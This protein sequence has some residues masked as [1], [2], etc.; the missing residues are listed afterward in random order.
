MKLTQK[1]CEN[2]KPKEKS[3]KLSDGE[4][5]YLEIMQN[6]SKYFRMKYRFQGKEKRLAL[7]VYP[8]VSLQ[9][10]REKRRSAKK[11]LEQG[12]D[13]SE[14][15]KLEKINHQ[16]NYEN[17][18]KTIAYE[19]H[20]QNAHT[21]TAIHGARIL[22]R[23]EKD[24][25]PQMGD[26]PIQEI[27]PPEVLAAIRQI[28]AR[29]VNELA[30]R[31]MQ[32]CSQVFRY[33][34]A[35]G[36]TGRDVT[37]DLRGALKPVVTKHLA[38]LKEAELPDFLYRLNHYEECGGSIL[39]KLAFQFLILTFVRSSEIR[40][41]TW[42]EIDY[43][44]AQWR[45]PASRMKMKEQHIVPLSKQSIHLLKQIHEITGNNFNNYILPNQYNPRKIM[46]ENTFLRVI[47]VLGY[48]GRTTAHGFRSVASTILN[49]R[50]YKADVIE[51][52]LAHAE[53]NQ[54][55]AAYNHAEYLGERKIMMQ[56]W[57]DYIDHA[58]KGVVVNFQKKV[59]G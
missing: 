21:W 4:G 26:R 54:I 30:H 29:G 15:K 34:V 25:F 33:G 27:T 35:T 8:N 39:T 57:A 16:A 48:K 2:A 28:E 1:A 32:T 9:E 37:V 22:K 41:A 45:I 40:G 17:T 14:Q 42:D 36:R 46:S 44:K 6:G 52:Q 24:I 3:Y 59:S 43:D 31:T 12:L 5:L 11:K 38:H 23:L 19:W 49:E 13:P 47:E 56:A 58:T 51:R 20:N 55:R 53:R 10:A 50:G 18:F 7:G